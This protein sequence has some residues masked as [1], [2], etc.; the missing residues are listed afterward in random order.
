MSIVKVFVNEKQ[1]SPEQFNVDAVT[2]TITLHR[3]WWRQKWN[4][5]RRI[6]GRP[7]QEHIV[8][9]Y[10]TDQQWLYRRDYKSATLESGQSVFHIPPESE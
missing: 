5:F 4:E 10:E 3:P 7:V 8:V 6:I 1:L 2:N 9:L